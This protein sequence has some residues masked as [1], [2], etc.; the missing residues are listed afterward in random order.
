M[1]E[2]AGDAVFLH[3]LLDDLVPAPAQVPDEVIHFTA[4]AVAHLR[5]HGF[6][7]REAAGDLAAVAAAGAPADA[8]GF[9]HRHFQAALGQLHGGGYAGETAADNGYVDL[10]GALE[11]RVLRVVVE[12]GTVVGRRALGRAVVHCCV[13]GCSLF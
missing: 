4:Q 5:A 9:H 6:V 7:A 11:L 13:H 3:P 1:L 10:H 2:V 12:G 8:V